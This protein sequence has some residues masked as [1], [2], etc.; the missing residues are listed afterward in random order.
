LLTWIGWQVHEGLR[1]WHGHEV[2]TWRMFEL[3]DRS[4]IAWGVDIMI[5]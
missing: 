5:V 3:N 2:Q 1:H 4:C